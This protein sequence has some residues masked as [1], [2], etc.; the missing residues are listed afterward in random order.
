[1][2]LQPASELTVSWRVHAHTNAAAIYWYPMV[3]DLFVPPAIDEAHPDDYPE[4][5]GLL[6]DQNWLDD[7]QDF[8]REYAR[9]YVDGVVVDAA[10]PGEHSRID[11]V[12]RLEVQP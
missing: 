8:E 7:Q 3:V 2:S 4:R 12:E 1:M 6:V 11:E 5:V 9:N 10:E